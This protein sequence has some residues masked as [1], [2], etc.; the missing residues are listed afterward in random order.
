MFNKLFEKL[1]EANGQEEIIEV[2]AVIKDGY[3]SK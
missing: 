1:I 3:G 2:L